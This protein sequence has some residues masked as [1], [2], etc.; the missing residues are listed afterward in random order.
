[1]QRSCSVKKQRRIR[2]LLVGQFKISQPETAVALNLRQ[3]CHVIKRDQTGSR[4]RRTSLCGRATVMNANAVM[5]KCE[6]RN[7]RRALRHVTTNT[8]VTSVQPVAMCLVEAAPLRL[9]TTDARLPKVRHA[10]GIGWRPM[11][12]VTGGT[13]EA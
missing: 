8:V 4:L 13:R 1:M 3:V 11:R 12:I 9:M 2:G 7:V 6:M 5:C 10:R